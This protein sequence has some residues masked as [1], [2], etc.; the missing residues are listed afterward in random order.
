[1]EGA[2]SISIKPLFADRR[3]LHGKNRASLK[4]TSYSFA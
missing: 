4:D 1:M 2:V 3:H